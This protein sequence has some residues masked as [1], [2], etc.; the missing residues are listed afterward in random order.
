MRSP[1]FPDGDRRFVQAA[2]WIVLGRAPN[3][4]ELRDQLQRF[5]AGQ[6]RS[7][8]DRLLTSPE[9]RLVIYSKWH[10]GAEIGRDPASHEAALRTLGPAEAF[11]D[12]AF[13]ILLGRN[14]DPEGRAYYTAAIEK[15]GARIQVLRA[16]VLSENSTGGI[17]KSRRTPACCRGTCSFASSPIRRN[18]TTRSG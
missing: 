17:A 10:D 15:G 3:D 16:L 11:V 14:P 2:F 13:A 7:F 9:F 6:E 1:D 8:A 5:A 4:V 12:L 18:G